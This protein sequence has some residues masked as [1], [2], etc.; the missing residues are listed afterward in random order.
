M[1]C[2]KI[3]SFAIQSTDLMRHSIKLQYALTFIMLMLGTLVLCLLSS[4]LFLR[5]YYE[6]EKKK[7][8][9]NV[10]SQLNTGSMDDQDFL[11]GIGLICSK[12]DLS[13]ILLD[14]Q[15]VGKYAVFGDQV[16]LQNKLLLHMKAGFEGATIGT[17]LLETGN[18]VLKLLDDQ[19]LMTK[20]L[21]LY[22]FLENGS[23][24]LISTP[25]VGMS[26]NAAISNRFF[27]FV[28]LVGAVIG[29]IIIFLLSYRV[30]KPILKLTQISKDMT[31]F[32][33]EARYEGGEQNEL[34][35]LGSNLNK[36]SAALEKT[37]TELK[38]ANN[39][40]RRDLATKNE[41]EQ[42]RSDF[43]SGVSHDLKTPIALIQGYAEA[44]N[45]CGDDLDREYY[46]G[47]IID[48]SR[49]MSDMLKGLLTLEQIEAGSVKDEL[50]RFDLM[51][52]I[53]NTCYIFRKY[54]DELGVQMRVESN[55][56]RCFVWSSEW[57][58]DQILRNYISNAINYSDK[59]EPVV[60]SLY[61]GDK[62][63]VLRCFVPH[64]VDLASVSRRPPSKDTV[65]SHNADLAAD[66]ERQA[67]SCTGASEADTGDLALGTGRQAESCTGAS[68]ADIGNL[69]L[70]KTV[71]VSVYNSG[72]PI[73]DAIKDKIWEKFFKADK[74]R[75]RGFSGNGIGLSLV[76]AAQDSLGREYGME[77]VE[78]GVVFWFEV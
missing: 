5:S 39:E 48:E 35:E 59:R 42:K 65:V 22:G 69:A 47:V 4:N 37:I 72:L 20:E 41:L 27:L 70:G 28:I 33:F 31:R 45:D 36:L 58:I 40:L 55:I 38:N 19:S 15:S 67:E 6:Y 56:K 32:N 24:L 10:Y 17:I 63:E 73:P 2:F 23:P 34:G 21:V 60:V 11:G 18:Y 49:K 76:K 29:S 57:K 68:E 62:Y 16:T 77:N 53:N 1:I 51:E 25:M 8:V 78:G 14:T 44:L 52:L 12:Q 61:A 54:A 74:A 3:G 46:C 7:T 30:S 66:N 13:L 43:L 9:L 75:T 64:D 26:T 50:E 71:R